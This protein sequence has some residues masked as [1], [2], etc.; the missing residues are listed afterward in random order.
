ME[1]GLIVLKYGVRSTKCMMIANGI[2]RGSIAKDQYY[3]SWEKDKVESEYQ[4][5]LFSADAKGTVKSKEDFYN[6]MGDWKDKKYQQF[7]WVE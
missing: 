3:I 1:H 4:G 7:T 2:T 6:L 5:F